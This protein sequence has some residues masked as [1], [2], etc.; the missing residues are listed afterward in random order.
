M[1]SIKMQI[2]LAVVAAIVTGLLLLEISYHLTPSTLN[3]ISPIPIPST[4][5]Q[6]V[7]ASLWIA[8]ATLIA[9]SITGSAILIN[10]IKQK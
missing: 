2:T 7:I 8:V 3:D 1:K 6:I 9:V 10:R 5:H 4:T